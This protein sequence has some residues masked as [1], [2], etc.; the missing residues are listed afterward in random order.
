MWARYG[1]R[2]DKELW[3]TL[4]SIT[5]WTDEDVAREEE[6][7]ARFRDVKPNFAIDCYSELISLTGADRSAPSRSSP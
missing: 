1:T 6:L 5:H 2:Y 3:K 7:Q 4:V